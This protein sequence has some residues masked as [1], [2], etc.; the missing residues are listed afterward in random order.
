MIFGGL[1]GALIA[2][3]AKGIFLGIEQLDSGFGWLSIP[4]NAL[5]TPAMLFVDLLML[6][7]PASYCPGPLSA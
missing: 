2:C 4:I 3:V 6:T 5:V 7:A 1:V